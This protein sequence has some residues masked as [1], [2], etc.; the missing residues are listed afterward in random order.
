MVSLGASEISPNQP[1][2]KV[3]TKTWSRDSHGLFDYE[4]TNT[5][6]FIL[7]VSG[8]TK[9]VRKKNDV[10][11]CSESAELELEDRE[12]CKV[13]FEDGKRS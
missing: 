6:N 2:L 11:Q 5:K 7:F 8:R 12:L 13:R 3:M 4:A 1:M 9:L 10:R